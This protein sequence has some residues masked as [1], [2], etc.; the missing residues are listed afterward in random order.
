MNS[1]FT[2]KFTTVLL[3]FTIIGHAT[4]FHHVIDKYFVCYG[5]DGHVAIEKVN[6]CENCSDNH[7]LIEQNAVKTASIN[8]NNCIDVSL[9]DFCYEANQY[10]TKNIILIPSLLPQN[11]SNIFQ[12]DEKTILS[13][14]T[15]NYLFRNPPL[16]NYTT[17]SLLI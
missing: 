11:Y 7:Y 10:I 17:V 3:L 1:N 4:F 16:H 15:Y 12:P 6:E 9:H 5:A 8:N 13:F 2:H 14:L